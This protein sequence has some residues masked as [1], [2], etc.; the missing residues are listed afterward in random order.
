MADIRVERLR[1]V[2]G[3]VVALDDV[4]FSFPDSSVTC[5]LGPSGCGK[6][7]LMRIIAGLEAPTAGEVFF[8]ERRVTGLPPRKREIGMVFQYP[9]V[10]KGIN[11]R[12]NIE[13]PLK[14]EKLSAAERRRRVDEVIEVL[15][16]AAAADK[17]VGRLD[18][19]TRQKVAVAREVARQPRIILFDE[20]ITNVDATA[21]LQLKRAFKELTRRLSQTI[22][23]VTHDQ[24]EAM[25]LA[26]QI[27]LM[28]DGRIVQ[29]DAPRT[30]YN[31]PADRFGGWF[32]GNPGMAFFDAELHGSGAFLTLVSPLLPAPLAVDAPL[33]APGPVTL[34]IRPEQLLVSVERASAAMPARLTRKS[35]QIGGQWL[36][37]LTVP[38]LDQLAF[39]AK[40]SPEHGARLPETGEVFV[41]LPPASITL[42]G[43]DGERLPATFP[44][45]SA[46]A[47]D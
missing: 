9:V 12:E 44:A 34:G 29:C 46:V 25:T 45:A 43:P 28:R 1:K 15:G 30:L 40:V 11:V 14:S 39:K 41:A 7:T 42:F 18:N 10:Y 26:D 47:A 2:F 32:L 20:P 24:T 23:Y 27:A 4:D 6:T 17:D 36:L 8:G 19:G 37:S 13:L 21:K 33:L 31:R 22:V 3:P 5:L 16:L 38:G 35:V